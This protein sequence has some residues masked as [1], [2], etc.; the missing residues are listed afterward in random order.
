MTWL[1]P[2]GWTHVM[3]SASLAKAANA[4]QTSTSGSD[5]SWL[6]ASAQLSD[7]ASLLVVQLVN[8]AA[9]GQPGQVTI[10]LEGTGFTPSGA[11]VV[12]TLSDPAAAGGAASPNPFAGNTPWQPT[13]ISPQP[14]YLTWPEGST[15]WTVS[16][17][18]SSFWVME[19]YGSSSDAGATT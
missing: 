7:D 15:T 3:V 18:A 16:V 4:L 2:P 13:Y 8:Q 6:S 1:Q 5:A 14:L 19:V 17:P 11:V 9:S 12:S 10:S